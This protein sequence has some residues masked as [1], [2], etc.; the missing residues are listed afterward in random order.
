MLLRAQRSDALGPYIRKRYCV[1][2]TISVYAEP[3]QV[4]FSAPSISVQ[5]TI[6]NLVI[7]DQETKQI[8]ALGIEAREITRSEN[9]K[10]KIELERERKIETHHPF[11]HKLFYP[12]L[13]T[14]FLQY[15]FFFFLRHSDVHSLFQMY[16]RRYLSK[17]DCSLTIRDYYKVGLEKQDELHQELHKDQTILKLYRI[18]V[19]GEIL[20]MRSQRRS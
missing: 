8:L 18:S 3:E 12:K 13:I 14:R 4:I 20:D 16:R 11:T 5:E 10:Q 7:L 17:Y 19:N 6:P 15:Y 1:I 2:I 9:I